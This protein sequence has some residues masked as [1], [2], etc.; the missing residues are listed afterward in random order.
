MFAAVPRAALHHTVVPAP[1]VPFPEPLQVLQDQLV[2][3]HAQAAAYESQLLAV[4]QV[5]REHDIHPE[6]AAPLSVLV[7]RAELP[8]MVRAALARRQA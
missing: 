7:E 1:T 5:L 4:L 2:A 6:R 3:A 8:R